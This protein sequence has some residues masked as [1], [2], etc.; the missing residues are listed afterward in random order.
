MYDLNVALCIATRN[1]PDDLSECLRAAGKSTMPLKEIIVSDDSTDTRTREL[2]CS[3]FPHVKFLEGPRKG[4]GPNRNNIIPAVTADWMLFMDDDT[5]LGSDFLAKMTPMVSARH[6]EKVIYS[7]LE[8][9]RGE[10]IIPRDLD[11]LGYQS[12]AYGPKDPINTLV[13]DATLF[14]A[15][16]CR[17][18]LFDPRLIYGYDEVDI[19][20]RARAAG[21]QIQI[22]PDAFIYHFPSQIGREHY[23][24]NCEVAR[25]FVVFKHYLKGQGKPFKAGAFLGAGFA[26][27][28]AHYVKSY[29][30]LGVPRSLS[31]Q[32]KVIRQ[33]A[34][35]ALVRGKPDQDLGAR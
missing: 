24:P 26:H 16:L 6:D 3:Q 10:L 2:V 8:I 5:R 33:I 30:I 29:G 14:P 17:E 23:K 35:W 15:T 21:W 25:I 12:R 7:G 19:A 1:R 9:N 13:I 22:C 34:E 18:L 31:V 4:L 28:L 32:G 20:L 11:F 27:N